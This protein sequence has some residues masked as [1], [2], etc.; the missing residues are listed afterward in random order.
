MFGRGIN[1]P[2]FDCRIWF[3]LFKYC[4]ERLLAKHKDDLSLEKLQL[5]EQLHCRNFSWYLHNIYPEMFVPDLKPTFY[6][7]VSLENHPHRI[8]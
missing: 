3:S 4:C 1:E 7:A 8:P 2:Q 5:R 6:G